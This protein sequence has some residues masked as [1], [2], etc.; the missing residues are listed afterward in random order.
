MTIRQAEGNRTPREQGS[1]SRGNVRGVADAAFE[2]EYA[3]FSEALPTLLK[4]YS[5]LYVAFRDGQ[6]VGFDTSEVRLAA[7]AASEWP[8]SYVLVRKVTPEAQEVQMR[9]PEICK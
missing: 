1:A 9:S 8:E 2:R 6:V 4:E 5:G 7:R 3:A